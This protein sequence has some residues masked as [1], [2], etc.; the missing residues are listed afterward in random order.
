MTKTSGE[1]PAREE[2][3]WTKEPPKEDGWYWIS[4]TVYNYK[5]AIVRVKSGNVFLDAGNVTAIY[6]VNSFCE[7][8]AH[9]LQWLKI[10]IPALPEEGEPNDE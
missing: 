5:P 3:K 10:D 2:P 4:Q 1:P 9:K 7:N 6:P 8:Y